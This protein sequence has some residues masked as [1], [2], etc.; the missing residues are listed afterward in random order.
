MPKTVNTN[1]Q[2]MQRDYPAEAFHLDCGAFELGQS[3]E[4]Q[5]PIKILARSKG[6]VTTYYWGPIVHDFA[7][8]RHKDTVPIDYRHNPDQMI[9][10]LD[11]F[12]ITG[13]GLEVAGAIVP[14]GEEDIAN[15]VIYK[16]QHRVPYEASIFWG[17]EGVKLEELTSGASAKVN[18]QTFHGPGIIVREW[19]LRGVAVCPYGR[20]ANTRSKLSQNETISVT[21]VN[22]KEENLMSDPV[23]KTAAEENLAVSVVPKDTNA[24]GQGMLRKLS[25]GLASMMGLGA[26]EE[27]QDSD[28]QQQAGDSGQQTAETAEAQQTQAAAEVAEAEAL[29]QKEAEQATR[30]KEYMLDF[31]E[32]GAKCFAEGKSYPEASR[33]Y[34]AALQEQ[35]AALKGKLHAIDRGAEEP[36]EFQADDETLAPA[37]SD[38]AFNLGNRRARKA[39]LIA[40]HRGNNK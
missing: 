21:F 29:K 23:L 34:V 17:G 19:T 18:G 11:R 3:D 14:F 38:E 30:L 20:D 27:S 28:D 2:E 12:S 8:M 9:G 24:E 22:H 32:L 6:A 7:G 4:G 35:I 15:Q 40:Q 36:A 39:A 31:G 33:L 10:F 1:K 13:K 26:S 37:T 16:A 5:T 25:A